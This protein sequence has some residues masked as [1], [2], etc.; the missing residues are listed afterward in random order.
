MG[1][2]GL[3]GLLKSI[4]RQTTLKAYSGQTLGVDAFG[5]LHRGAA[6]CAYQL[7]VDKPTTFYITFVL[8]R[9]RMLLDFG[10]TPYLVFDGDA[11][12]SKAETNAKRREERNAAKELGLSLLKSG[13]REEAL[14][15]FQKAVSITPQMTFNL[16][17]ELRRMNVQVLVAPYEADAQLVYLEKEG[18]IDGIISEDSDMLVFGAQRLITK[19]DQHASCVEIRRV[20]F[21]LNKEVSLAGWSDAM[22]R[23]MAILSGCDYLKNVNG[24][25]LRTAHGFVKRHKEIKKITRMMALSGKYVIPSDYLANFEAAERAFLYQRVFCPNAGRLVFL[26]AIPP[27]LNE[28]DLLFLGADVEPEIAIGVAC[29]DLHP[30]TKQP[31]KS[32]KGSAT[33]RPSP[34]GRRQTLNSSA[35]LKPKRSIDSFFKPHRVPLAELDP[36]CLTPS[37]SQQ[38]VLDRNRNASWQART[39]SSAPPLRRPRAGG[40]P[41]LI[42][43]NT[44]QTDR[45][46]FLSKA[47][48]SSTFQ[49]AK[50]QRLCSDS[51]EVSPSKEIKQSRF[52]SHGP[53]EQSP[54]TNKKTRDRHLRK[55]TFDVFADDTEEGIV[56]SLEEQVTEAA[57]RE[58]LHPSLPEF[59]Q[60]EASVDDIEF[61]PQSSPVKRQ[62]SFI[63]SQSS[64]GTAEIAAMS[65]RSECDDDPTAFE[66]L[67]SYQIDSSGES[68]KARGLYRTFL[69]QSFEVQAAALSTLKVPQDRTAKN[70][71]SDLE[72]STEDIPSPRPAT[73]SKFRSFARTFACQP[74]G[75]QA[76]A[77]QS[78]GKASANSNIGKAKDTIPDRGS[79]DTLPMSSDTE[80]E[81]IGEQPKREL[82]IK[83]FHYQTG[84]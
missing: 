63:E 72:P 38:Q 84:R 21:L 45:I 26:N 51:D 2:S 81:E 8:N 34:L 31:F 55:S 13:K 32:L 60:V 18:I 28:E 5:W 43:P 79:E 30:K 15:K 65:F 64:H 16:I 73:T 11:L 7:A 83:S 74:A 48:A 3:L 68:I 57:S 9:V 47:G 59:P 17:E 75:R 69:D 40:I 36:N 62:D 33:P 46:L 41:A 24:V 50:R 61:V 71:E 56:L 82:D 10:I 23:R 58:K 37:P 52:F 6:G 44:I 66:D 67:L 78:L 19:L 14:L 42:T 35:D 53:A 12:P 22:F 20:D 76:H 25:G 1:V 80:I 49:P 27:D 77:L 4:Q 29:G 54:L 39:V 70:E